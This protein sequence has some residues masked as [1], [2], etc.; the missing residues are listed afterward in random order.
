MNDHKQD[1]TQAEPEQRPLGVATRPRLRRIV[2][3]AL[4]IE[5]APEG[6]REWDYCEGDPPL[7]TDEIRQR[8]PKLYATE[9]DEDPIVQV[10]FR[11][12]SGCHWNVVEF[13]GENIFFGLIW[14]RYPIWGY[15]ALSHLETI[16][17]RHGASAIV[18]DPGF[19]PEPVS[20]AIW[21]YRDPWS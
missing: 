16:N 11:A 14:Q 13:D 2:P 20:S 4:S 10:R 7:L 19:E 1:Q 18:V 21:D 6:H 9:N 12:W 3:A 5:V 15:F 17:A 8:L